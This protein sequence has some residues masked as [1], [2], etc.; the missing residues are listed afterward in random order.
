M[1]V[2]SKEQGLK[3]AQSEANK[4]G[5]PRWVG[6]SSDGDW[7]VDKRPNLPGSIKV[8]P[9][10]KPLIEYAET[11]ASIL[12][13]D[14]EDTPT[15]EELTSGVVKGWAD[16]ETNHIVKCFRHGITPQACA[17]GIENEDYMK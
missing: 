6:Q 3:L 4:D 10:L 9:V 2:P 16:A 8:E 17:E 15:I 7:W 5:K 12:D 14:E 1:N 11:V 13:W